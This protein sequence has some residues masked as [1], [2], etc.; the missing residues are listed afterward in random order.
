MKKISNRS[1]RT[2]I[3]ERLILLQKECLEIMVQESH[4]E[5]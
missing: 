1:D 3:R 2:I 4:D 5:D